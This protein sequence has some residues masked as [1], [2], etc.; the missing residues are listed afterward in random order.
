MDTNVTL[1]DLTAIGFTEQESQVILSST[2]SGEK[3]RLLRLGRARLLDDIH[4]RQQTLDRL[5]YLI[6]KIRQSTD[7]TR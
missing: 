4:G 5:D 7:Q 2:S 6:H 3:I 1:Y